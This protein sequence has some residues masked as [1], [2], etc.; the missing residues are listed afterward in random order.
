[1]PADRLTEPTPTSGM[2]SSNVPPDAAH[3]DTTGSLERAILEVLGGTAPTLVATSHAIPVDR[4]AEAA[5]RY[6]RAGRRTLYGPADGVGWVHIAVV[7]PR[8]DDAENTVA[9]HL[10]PHIHELESTGVITAWWF[11]RKA[12]AWRIRFQPGV[13][14]TRY[15]RE[16][17][18]L[19]LDEL[20]SRQL[21]V[22]W[23]PGVYEP[24]TQAFGGLDA[25]R[26]A[27][28]LFHTDSEAIL[29]YVARRR[30]PHPHPAGLLGRREVSLIICGALLRAAGQDRYERGDIWHRVT[31][32]R[33]LPDDIHTDRASSLTSKIRKLLALDA[34]P[35]SP[36]AQPNRPLHFARPWLSAVTNAGRELQTYASQGAL[37]RG[38]RDVLAHHLIFH[39]NRLGLRATTQGL[40]AMIARDAAFAARSEDIDAN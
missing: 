20:A 36:L 16:A 23:S 5:A 31:Y 6:R 18:G 25:M 12:P 11:V 4:L 34:T 27:H 37:D 39:W 30:Q 19:V 29:G 35:D 2:G 28:S 9:V 13:N 1:M 40:L 21:I 14:Q 17:I 32:L 33:P 22:R 10:W 15:A 3:A 26:T 7:F 24:E 38:L 8:W